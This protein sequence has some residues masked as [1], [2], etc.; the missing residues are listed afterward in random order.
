MDA[1]PRRGGMVPAC[2][3]K[4]WTTGSIR[5]VSRLEDHSTG[6]AF[7]SGG[8]PDSGIS[9]RSSPLTVAGQRRIFT[10]LPNSPWRDLT[11]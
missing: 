2:A 10:G 1:W 5:L 6:H 11:E 3:S 9:W 7:P 8:K 4:P